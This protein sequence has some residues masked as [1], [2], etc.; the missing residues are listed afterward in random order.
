MKKIIYIL[1]VL[2]SF[3]SCE[4]YPEPGSQTIES[5]NFYIIGNQQSSE[6]GQYLTDA[7]GVQINLES[8]IPKTD[9]KFHMVLEMTSGNGTVEQSIVEADNEGKML[10]R[11]KL[12][13]EVNDQQ[14]TGFIYDSSERFYSE[15]EIQATAFFPDKLNTITNGFLIGIGDMVKDTINN[16]SMMISG[17][18]LYVKEGIDNKFYEWQQI[19]EYGYPNNFKDI[20]INSKGEVFGGG[21]NG[22]LYKSVDWGKTWSL[23]SKPIPENP[24]NFEL[25]ISKDDFIWVSR[26]DK[27]MYCST[28]GGHTWQNDTSIVEAYKPLGPVCQLNDTS[29]VALAQNIMQT[30]DDG[31][32]WNVINTPQYSS[33]IYV[34]D[35]NEII[36]QNQQ[37]GMYKSTD[38][39][40]TFK[41]VLSPHV[42]YGTTSWHCYDKFKNNYYVL[43]PGGGVWKTRNFEEFENLITFS[44]QRNLFIDH[45][46]TI[47]ASGFNYSNAADDPTLVLPNNE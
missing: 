6:A 41:K 29:H 23:V 32:H 3:N 37:G 10:T 34:T 39:G 1:I 15:F 27:N 9:K 21:W 40:L 16:R 30:F 44:V 12:G 28:D 45:T 43:A 47:Y 42:A 46:G 26:W 20:E 33:T 22:N 11:W 36:L 19:K 25:S 2:V 7:V 35:N 5:F 4:K 14:I 31:V 38:S 8:L 18:E 17:M 24:Y 13:D